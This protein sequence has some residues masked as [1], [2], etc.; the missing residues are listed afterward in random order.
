MVEAVI[1]DCDGVLVNS[2]EIYKRV[3]HQ[4]LT[5][6]GHAFDSHAYSDRFLGVTFDFYTAELNRE[7]LR[8][9]GRPLPDGFTERIYALTEAELAHSLLAH[10]GVADAVA[11]FPGAKAVASSSGAKRLRWKLEKVGLYHA[12]APHVYSAD[13]VKHGKPAP[14]LFL[15]AAEKLSLAPAGCAA[16]EDSFNG[17]RSAATA[18]MKVIGYIG[19]RHCPPHQADKLRSAGAV[20]VIDHMNQ[21]LP[22]LAKLG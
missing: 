21:L 20:A 1:F 17:V 9:H 16:V 6:V 22:T 12:F 8:Q 7:H 13:A 11:T 2:E 14:D 5:E 4:C 3:E 10:D 19:G 18:G 15:H